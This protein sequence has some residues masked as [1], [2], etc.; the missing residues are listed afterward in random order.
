MLKPKEQI[1]LLNR[2][3][4]L[5]ITNAPL[6]GSEADIVIDVG[7]LL[8]M[9]K[10]LGHQHGGAITPGDVL[11]TFAHEAIAARESVMLVH[12]MMA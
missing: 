12:E 2:L 9:H 3:A 1:E 6:D 7:R 11:E 5:E 8:E 10:E 4:D